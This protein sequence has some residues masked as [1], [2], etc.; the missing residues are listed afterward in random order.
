M[1]LHAGDVIR[2]G[3]ATVEYVAGQP[4]ETV[5][6]GPQQSSPPRSD[7]LRVDPQAY[8]VWLGEQPRNG[9][10]KEN[11]ELSAEESTLLKFLAAA[12]A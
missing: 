6:L 2:I 10:G 9:N 1:P 5:T 12:A 7:L 8:E 3:D 4:G 11:G